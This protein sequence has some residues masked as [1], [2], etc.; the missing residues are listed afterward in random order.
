MVSPVC[1]IVIIIIFHKER[2]ILRQRIHNAPSKGIVS[3]SVILQALRIQR[4]FLLIPGIRRVFRV[5][6]SFRIHPGHIIH[7]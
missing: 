2:R 7:R 1:L 6:I 3:V 5:K 4:F